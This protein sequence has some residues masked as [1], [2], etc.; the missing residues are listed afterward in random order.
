VL[1]QAENMGSVNKPVE[2]YVGSGLLF[3]TGSLTIIWGL[4]GLVTYGLW[5]LLDVC[6]GVLLVFI[7]YLMH[8]TLYLIVCSVTSIV[9]GLALGIVFTCTNQIVGVWRAVLIIIAGVLGLAAQGRTRQRKKTSS[10]LLRLL[11]PNKRLRI[12]D[13][14]SKL[15]TSEAEV[16][17]FIIRLRKGGTP[18]RFNME[19]REVIYGRENK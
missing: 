13:L 8:R 9:I 14:A 19:T 7:G 15:A 3:L 1:A 6:I 11:I 16:E 5:S 10:E 4:V 18:I 2:T 12:D 17:M